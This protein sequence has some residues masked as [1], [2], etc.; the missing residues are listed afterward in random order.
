MTDPDYDRLS[1]C[2]TIGERQTFPKLHMIANRM[3][4]EQTLTQC[5]SEI[6]E[7]IDHKS[8]HRGF[9][10]GILSEDSENTIKARINAYR[11]EENSGD[12]PS[13]GIRRR[14]RGTS[15]PNLRHALGRESVANY[16]HPKNQEIGDDDDSY[17][18]EDEDDNAILSG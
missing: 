18:E 7:K 16:N 2:L 13:D 8:N 10:S 14:R 17:L 15:W 6:K 1:H 12:N 3:R 11:N 4:I 9:F 5:R